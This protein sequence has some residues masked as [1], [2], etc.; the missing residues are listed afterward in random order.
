MAYLNN[1]LPRIESTIPVD[2]AEEVELTSPISIVFNT[3]MNPDTITSDNIYLEID[4]ITYNVPQVQ[5]AVEYDGTSKTATIT[6]AN[7]LQPGTTYRIIV[8]KNVK[9]TI[10]TSPSSEINDITFKTTTKGYLPAPKLVSPS[11]S[12]LISDSNPTLVWEMVDGATRYHVQI[13]SDKNFNIILWE[14]QDVSNTSIATGTELEVGDDVARFYYWRVRAYDIDDAGEWSLT[15]VFNN[16]TYSQERVASEYHSLEII[17][18]KPN[19]D[20]ALVSVSDTTISV[21]FSDTVDNNTVNASTFY[22]TYKPVDGDP[23]ISSGTLTGDITVIDD[24]IMLTPS[25][26]LITNME[27]TVVIRNSIK[28]NSGL[29]LEEDTMWTFTSAMNP[30]YAGAEIIRTDIG[31]FIE[32]VTDNDIYK[33]ILDVSRWANL[34][35]S[36]PYGSTIDYFSGQKNDMYFRNY[37]RYETELRLLNRRILEIADQQGKK[38]RLGEL[39][40]QNDTSLVP[41]INIALKPTQVKTKE[42][43]QLL[44]G[45]PKARPRSVQQGG[46]YPYG[47]RQW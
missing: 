44:R 2:G 20:A 18:V 6:P 12:S 22:V 16:A 13:S 33:I 31:K 39:E 23:T 9:S 10:G 40:I 36:A 3:Y 42:F 26:S 17:S 11:N 21:Q 7:P 38:V 5:I 32:N 35:S 46:E 29:S 47:S 14:S 41:D 28:S 8:T 19:V 37:T 27:Y 43:E 30:L 15:W 34:I 45:S 25:A 1:M 24:T 4:G